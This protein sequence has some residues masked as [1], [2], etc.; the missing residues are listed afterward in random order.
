MF[1]LYNSVYICDEK[2]EDG[3]VGMPVDIVTFILPK[4]VTLS[5][6][7][8]QIPAP[9]RPLLSAIYFQIK[10][11]RRNSKV[12]LSH[13]SMFDVCVSVV[14]DCLSDHY[15]VA[16][17]V[18]C[19]ELLLTVH[20]EELLLTFQVATSHSRPWLFPSVEHLVIITRS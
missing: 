18:L 15:M 19:E 12:M 6:K 16:Q 5:E 1:L 13:K 9:P 11:T 2:V 20:C 17:S 3:K 4:S 7:Q 10:A 8:D 14:T